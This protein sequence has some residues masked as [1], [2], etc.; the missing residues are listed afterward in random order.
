MLT[1]SYIQD[2]VPAGKIAYTG[3][4]SSAD[5]FR[6]V[7]FDMI[8][9]GEIKFEQNEIDSIQALVFLDDEGF[10]QLKAQRSAMGDD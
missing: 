5:Y 4:S 1:G 6:E 3:T 10:E 7:G 2:K 9:I 8:S